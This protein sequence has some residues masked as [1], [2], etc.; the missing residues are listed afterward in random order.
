MGQDGI[1][2]PAKHVVI[3]LVWPSFAMAVV[4]TGVFFSAI[5]PEQLVIYSESFPIGRLG[6]YTVGFLA[7]WWF[8]AM[9][10][11]LGLRTAV[12]NANAEIRRRQRT[13]GRRSEDDP[14]A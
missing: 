7:F 2:I 1:K 11:Y 9:S 3:A 5:D 4:A 12:S 14:S 8:S 6:V 13:E 10:I